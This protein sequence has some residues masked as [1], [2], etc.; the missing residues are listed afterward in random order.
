MGT[1]PRVCG[2][3][4]YDCR[5]VLFRGVGISTTSLSAH[6]AEA[7]GDE[8]LLPFDFAN[9][10]PVS[11]WRDAF[12]KESSILQVVYPLSFAAVYVGQMYT[13]VP[14]NGPDLFGIEKRTHESHPIIPSN[15]V[16]P[17]TRSRGPNPVTT[18]RRLQNVRCV[19]SFFAAGAV[20]ASVYT[21]PP[22]R[23]P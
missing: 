23:I 1:C 17:E 21:T 6:S 13:G 14:G 20:V 9:A 11:Q 12:A 4:M 10:F 19:L 8:V 22:C 18:F 7:P 5:W 16:S 2:G 15:R 3:S